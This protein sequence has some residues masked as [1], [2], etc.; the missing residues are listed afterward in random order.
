MLAIFV[1]ILIKVI[2]LISGGRTVFLFGMLVVRLLE[3]VRSRVLFGMGILAFIA[4]LLSPFLH[5]LLLLIVF[6]ILFRL[7]SIPP[8]GRLRPSLQIGAEHLHKLLMRDFP[9]LFIRGTHN[10]VV[11]M[12]I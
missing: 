9:T 10:I 7:L 8:F 6:V 2:G 1:S 11:F 12:L 5:I 4:H 3:I